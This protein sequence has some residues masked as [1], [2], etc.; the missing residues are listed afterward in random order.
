MKYADVKSIHKKNDKTDEE[1]I[2]MTDKY[3]PKFK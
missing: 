2:L 1:Y 3:S